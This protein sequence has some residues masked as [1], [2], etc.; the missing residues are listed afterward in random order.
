VTG[1][2]QRTP[3]GNH[4]KETASAIL[5]GCQLSLTKDGY[6]PDALTPERMRLAGNFL[7]FTKTFFYLRTG[8]LFDVSYPVGRQSHYVDISKELTGVFQGI[9]KRL[10]INVPPRYGKSELVIHFVAWS[11]A[12]YPDSN[13]MYVSYSHSL[14]KKMTQTIR[15]IVSMPHYKALFGVELKG[16]TTAKD[17][18]ETTVGGTVYAVGAGGTVTGRGAGVKS[19]NRFGGCVVIDDIH[20][21]DEA[22]SDTIREGINDWYYNTLQSRLNSPSTPIIF[23]GQRVHEDDLAANL[24]E[25]KEW[26]TLILAALDASGNALHPQMHDVRALKKL[27]E[28]SPYIYA[29][30]YQQDPQQAGTCD[31]AETDKDYNDATVFSFWGVAR[32]VQDYVDT[33]VY[34]LHWL[35][36]WELRIEPKDLQ[37]NFID[38]YRQCMRYK[39]RPRSI[40]IEKKSTGVTLLSA[41]KNMQGLTAM[42][43]LRDKRSKTERFLEAQPYVSSRRVSLPRYSKHTDLCIKHMGKITANNSHR[44][45]DIADTLSDAVHIALVKEEIGRRYF[46]QENRDHVAHVVSSKLRNINALKGDRDSNVYKGPWH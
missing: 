34:A 31:T 40:Y 37:A 46:N 42:D 29:A 4:S 5:A 39:V 13:F 36:C 3:A 2:N 14:A 25:T 32:I 11:L 16:D 35:D 12:H 10:I 19:V 44:F 23:I 28:D 9:N 43:I 8:R 17:N 24:I 15:D 30:Q 18:F 38:F 26:N 41:L 20:K 45:D 27:Q 7:E 21:P 1:R 6:M 22:T 33:G